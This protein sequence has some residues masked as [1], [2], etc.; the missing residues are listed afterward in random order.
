MWALSVTW[1]F[2][3]GSARLFLIM[4]ETEAEQA[5]STDSTGLTGCTPSPAAPL[6]CYKNARL[7]ITRDPAMLIPWM[8]SH[9]LCL[10][11]FLQLSSQQPSQP[12]Q[13]LPIPL[14]LPHNLKSLSHLKTSCIEI[15]LSISSSV[16]LLISIYRIST[17]FL[18]F[19]FSFYNVSLML[20]GGAENLSILF[21]SSSSNHPN[22]YHMSFFSGMLNQWINGI[23]R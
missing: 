9:A 17:C 22:T 6:L 19:N 10:T 14:A 3:G 23:L 5:G 13:A 21:Q 2:K 11:G 8:S 15:D 7:L 16:Y 12:I 4:M 1:K 18:F 20:E